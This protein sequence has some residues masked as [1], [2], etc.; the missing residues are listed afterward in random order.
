M[1]L[2]I[3]QND[4]KLHLFY[5]VPTFRTS[6]RSSHLMFLLGRL[7]SRID[8][9]HFWTSLTFGFQS[10]DIYSSWIVRDVCKLFSRPYAIDASLQ[11][12]LT[13]HL[14]VCELR[15]MESEPSLKY[16]V[17]PRSGIKI[18]Y[19]SNRIVRNDAKLTSIEQTST[20]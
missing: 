17:N 2:S 16:E 18:N 7:R 13:N 3:I 1:T 5:W 20:G 10:Q 9:S 4:G 14:H 19:K 12:L 8:T 6:C 11:G 15:N